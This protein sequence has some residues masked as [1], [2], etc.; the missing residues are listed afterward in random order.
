M[1]GT[2]AY[3]RTIGVEHAC[4][5]VIGHGVEIFE[6]V[7]RGGFVVVLFCDG[8]VGVCVDFAGAFGHFGGGCCCEGLGSGCDC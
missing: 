3:S 6:F 7:G 1:R 8:W 4:F 5:D 2:Y